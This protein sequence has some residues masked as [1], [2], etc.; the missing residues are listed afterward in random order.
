MRRNGSLIIGGMIA[1]SV[2]VIA[3]AAPWIAPFPNHA[4]GFVDFHHRHSP[5]GWPHL[6]GTD[7]VGR[8]ILSRICF[9]YRISLV[10]V[11]AVVGLST[12]LGVLL[13]ISAAYAGGWVE[14]A[15]MRFTDIILAIPPLVMALA[16]GAALTPSLSSALI[17]IVALWWTWDARLAYRAAKSVVAE[18]FIEAA[19]LAGAGHFHMI[20]KEIL[21]NC[22]GVILVQAAFD[23]G[24]V[25][26]FGGALSFLGLGVQPPTPDLG[27]MVAT[28]ARFL[29]EHWWEAAM[30]GL[31]I[32]YAILG[33][34]LIAD[35]LRA[36]L[37]PDR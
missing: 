20:F 9:G 17:A 29:P 7:N 13:G 21:P 4:G 2:V 11:V 28:G 10:L 8:D 1:I 30:P 33:F 26:L 14:S 6:L 37:D 36:A 19:K 22:L 3:L 25:I 12:P 15:I 27:T 32:L 18:D 23:A 34:L 35:G 16:I 5:P 31:A 24:F